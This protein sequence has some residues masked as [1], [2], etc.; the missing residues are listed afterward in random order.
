[1]VAVVKQVLMS[2]LLSL[3]MLMSLLLSL[4]MLMSLLLSLQMLMSLLALMSLLISL[5]LSLQMLMSLL[6]LMS[7]L[8]SLLLSLQMLMS[9]LL[10]LQMLMSLARMP[11][12]RSHIDSTVLARKL[13]TSWDEPAVERAQLLLVC[14][15]CRV[16]PDGLTPAEVLEGALTELEQESWTASASRR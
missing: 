2:L 7:L 13:R 15:S 5:L 12:A 6:A 10:S 1:L 9:L 4:Q 3:Q 14:V 11:L 8:I 16:W